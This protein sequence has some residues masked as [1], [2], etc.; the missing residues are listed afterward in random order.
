[1]PT[2][3]TL[4]ETQHSELTTQ[5]CMKCSQVCRANKRIGSHRTAPVQ[6][7]GDENFDFIILYMRLTHTHTHVG[8]LSSFIAA[9]RAYVATQH[10]HHDR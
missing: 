1:M 2:I 3:G 8:A 7:D 4:N 5:N 6:T 10:F 9:A